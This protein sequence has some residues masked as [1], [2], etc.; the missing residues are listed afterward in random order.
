MKKFLTSLLAAALMLTASGAMAK[1][2]ENLSVIKQKLIEYH[3]SG[4]YHQDIRKSL[5]PGMTYLMKRAAEP[6][7]NQKKLAIILDIDETSLSNFNDMKKLGFGGTK[8]SMRELEDKAQDPAIGPTL[9]LYKY[10]KSHD[11]AVFFVTGRHEPEREATVRNLKVAGF[12]NYDGLVLRY[13]EY[14]KAPAAKYKTAVRKK[15]TEEGYD[16]I[17]NIGDQYSDLAGGY[18]DKS[19]KLPNP[20]YLIP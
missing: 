4:A 17:L 3:D 8:E 11:V 13:G 9:E 5:T 16:I 19:I 1:E 18:A 2:I 15:L 6:R 20:Y 10:A 14:D 7:S 12:D